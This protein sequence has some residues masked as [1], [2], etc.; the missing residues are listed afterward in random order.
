M[1]IYDYE[2]QNMENN[3]HVS[4][5]L[6]KSLY[7]DLLRYANSCVDQRSLCWRGQKA[8]FEY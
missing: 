5:R 1:T 3:R 2:Q 6:D 4:R 7:E 8:S